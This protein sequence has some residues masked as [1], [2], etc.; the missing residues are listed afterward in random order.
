MSSTAAALAA[1]HPGLEAL[2]PVK[3]L[4]PLSTE[5]PRATPTTSSTSA[6]PATTDPPAAAPAAAQNTW[7]FGYGSLIW[8]PDFKYLERRGGYI[9]G[10]KRRFY[11]GSTDVRFP[12]PPVTPFSLGLSF[13]FLTHPSRP[14]LSF[15]P[16]YLPH[17][18]AA[19]PNTP[20]SL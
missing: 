19:R 20:A 16:F 10:F 7:V 14:F 13:P 6:D 17:S 4:S 15:A 1:A 3:P 8:K 11:Q 9:K 5:A 12:S 2:S 18:T